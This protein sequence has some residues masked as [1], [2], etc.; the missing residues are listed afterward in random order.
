MTHPNQLFPNVHIGLESE[1]GEYVI[2][3]VPAKGERPGEKQTRIGHSANIRSHTVIYAGNLIGQGLQ[4]GHG[5]LI[6]ELNQ[7]G[8]N[9]SIGSHSVIEHHVQI[10]H[11]VRIHSNVFIPEYSIC[12]LYT[13]PSPRD[14]S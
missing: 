8:D 11:G 1:I 10:G 12:L 13:S 5:V 14:R 2:V 9:V 4:T 3:G 6:R 7:I